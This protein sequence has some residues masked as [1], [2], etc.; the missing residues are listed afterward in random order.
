MK[1]Y[2]LLE[3]FNK[4]DS[5]LVNCKLAVLAKNIEKK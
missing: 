5:N 3:I 2:N 1:E 4:M